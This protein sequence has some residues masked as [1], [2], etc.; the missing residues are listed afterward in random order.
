VA[1]N[2]SL[3][4]ANPTTVMIQLEAFGTALRAEI[5]RCPE[6]FSIRGPPQNGLVRP[7]G[8]AITLCTFRGMS[9]RTVINPTAKLNQKATAGERTACVWRWHP[10]PS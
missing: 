9:E 7:Q 10:K 3:C 6:R 8:E 4:L 5:A 1:G 2:E